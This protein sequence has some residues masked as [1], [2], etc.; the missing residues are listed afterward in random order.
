MNRHTR[1]PRSALALA[2]F[3]AIAV[4]GQALAQDAGAQDL[5]ARIAQLEQMVQ[6][7]KAE[8]DAQKAA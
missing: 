3:L 1:Y 5:E 7:L 8:L 4:P 2:V 6:G